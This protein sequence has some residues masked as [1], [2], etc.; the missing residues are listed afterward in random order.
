MKNKKT[1]FFLNRIDVFGMKF[2]FDWMKNSNEHDYFSNDASERNG[3]NTTIGFSS[4]TSKKN[5]TS[6]KYPRNLRLS[7]KFDKNFFD[8]GTYFGLPN[9]RANCDVKWLSIGRNVIK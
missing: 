8:S 9:T 5:F 4:I 7:K 1:H 6:Q 3:S 2:Q